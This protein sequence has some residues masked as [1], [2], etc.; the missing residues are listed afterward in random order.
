VRWAGK[1]RSAAFSWRLNGGRANALRKANAASRR[2]HRELG[3][4]LARYVRLTPKTASG[5]VGLYAQGAGMIAQRVQVAGHIR[6]R[7]YVPAGPSLRARGLAAKRRVDRQFAAAVAA[8]V[9]AS[10]RRTRR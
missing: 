1:V 10:R 3:K 4:P 5:I 8:H 6:V 7:E 9:A 2:L